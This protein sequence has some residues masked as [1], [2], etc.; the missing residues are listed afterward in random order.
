MSGDEWITLFVLIGT[1][2]GLAVGRFP[3]SGVVLAA[4]ITLLLA[5]VLDAGEAFSGFSN[6]APLTVAALYVLAAGARRTGML[7]P[8]VSRVLGRPG[9]DRARLARLA[10]PTALASG[11]FNNT[12]LVAMMIPDVVAWSRRHGEAVSRLLL[13]LSYAAILG[14]TLTLLG[15][16]TNLV[17]SGLLEESGRDG[18]TMF[19]ITKVGGPV[20]LVGL[21]VLLTV[22]ARLIPD[23]TGAA[24]DVAATMREFTFEMEVVPGGAVD[25]TSVTAAGLRHLSG[26]Y[27]VE[28]H[29]DGGVLGP[30]DPD[31]ILVG[32][33]RLGFVGRIDQVVD[34]QQM[35]G[36][37][38]PATA[39]SISAPAGEL[40]FFEAVVGRESPVAGATLREARFRGR[41][42]AAVIAIHRAGHR[43]EAKL[44]DVRLRHGDTL[45]LMAGA[46]FRERWRE[47]RDF[48]LVARLDGAD[49]VVTAQAPIVAA[50][51]AGFVALAAAGVVTVLEGALLAA[52]ALVATRVLT[53]AEAKKAV[54]LDVV[55]LIGAALGLGRA[56]GVSGLA[57]RIAEGF[58]D[59]FDSMGDFGVVLGVV[60]ATTLL[61]EVVTNNAAAAVLM[62]IA[63]A[64]STTAGIDPRLM[65]SAVAVAASMS[66]LTPIGYQTNTM[67]YGPGG[68]RFSDY[69]RA[70]SPLTVAVV[71]T[72]AAV[73]TLL[74]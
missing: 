67:V 29:R 61:T 26:V 46:G 59:T 71:V 28:I 68:Y 35:A 6:P 25:G 33:D 42:D 64:I 39:R 2:M 74:N 9:R 66:F 16:S 53:F 63:L 10:A 8:V 11:V 32:G 20:A 5:D 56:V 15:T 62:P 57:E 45:V 70:G 13:P 49:P 73:V 47:G 23:R 60:V 40:A 41:Y 65:A 14:G 54:D 21:A 7:S 27:L 48:L 24:N 34:L 17:V 43:V 3:P 18:F 12:P 36:L 69:L 22:S 55:V 19:E 44:G 51:L 30:V 50:A 4:T 52:A 72:N 38:P 37:R 58:V 31:E 1:L